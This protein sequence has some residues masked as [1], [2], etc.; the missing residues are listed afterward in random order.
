MV[1]KKWYEARTSSNLNF[2]PSPIKKILEAMH[3]ARVPATRA[4]ASAQLI[5]AFPS[6]LCTI[7]HDNTKPNLILQGPHGLQRVF[8]LKNDVFP[9]PGG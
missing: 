2:S 1:C 9:D 5:S 8:A 7:L 3:S 6:A 4:P